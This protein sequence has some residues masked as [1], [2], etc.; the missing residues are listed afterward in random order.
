M[1]FTTM[2]IFLSLCASPL[3]A[4]L[5]LEDAKEFLSTNETMWMVRRSFIRY[6]T[7]GEENSCVNVKKVDVTNR[8]RY[9]YAHHHKEGQTWVDIF[10]YV[11]PLQGT[12]ADRD[13]IIDVS[14]EKDASQKQYRLRYWDKQN[15]CAIL[16]FKDTEGETTKCEM[17]QWEKDIRQEV[18]H[19][20][21]NRFDELCWEQ[22]YVVNKDCT[23]S[24]Q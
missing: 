19:L 20:C 13:A 3:G 8:D 16:T 9:K 4:H 21:D 14:I 10:I 17:Y 12:E 23:R 5:T 11:T 15:H 7:S 18:P 24:I 2:I 6:G 1:S 22:K